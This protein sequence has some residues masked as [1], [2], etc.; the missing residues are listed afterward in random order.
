[1]AVRLLFALAGSLAVLSPALS[2]QTPPSDSTAITDCDDIVCAAVYEPVCGSDGETY[3]NDCSFGAAQCKDITLSDFTVGECPEMVP[4]AGV[5]DCD[6]FDVCPAVYKPVCGSD[7]VTYS[8]DCA[9]GGAQ[10]NDPTIQTYRTGSCDDVGLAPPATTDG[11]TKMINGTVVAVNK[12][13]TG[14]NAPS[15]ATVTE[16]VILQDTTSVD[17]TKPNTDVNVTSNATVTEPVITKPSRTAKPTLRPVTA[18]PTA[19]PTAEL[20]LPPTERPTRP[21]VGRGVLVASISAYPGYTGDLTL[22]GSV[23]ILVEEYDLDFRFEG[24][25]AEAGCVNCGVHVHSGT[26]CSDA[27]LIL[28][29]YWTPADAPDPWTIQTTFY[30]SDADGAAVGSFNVD[31]G[32]GYAD[33]EGHAVVVHASD[34]SR[35]GCGILETQNISAGAESSDS[36]SA[37]KVTGAPSASKAT[38]SPSPSTR[39]SVPNEPV[40]GTNIESGVS[41]IRFGILPVLAAAAMLG[42][43]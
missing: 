6:M 43:L 17:I 14:V 29:H 13:S 19:E 15:N 10:C 3:S 41:R 36:Q 16:T 23:Q 28:G 12:P 18:E 2:E 7:G 11:A 24:T 25:G 37:A 4:V 38:A 35:I 42:V 30:V 20:T 8:N 1:M 27:D 34:N 26:S 5:V 9:F 33:N 32:Y 31:S 39:A 22:T 40:S 21:P